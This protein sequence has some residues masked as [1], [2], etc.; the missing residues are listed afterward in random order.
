M[1]VLGTVAECTGIRM[2]QEGL[3]RRGQLVKCI[4]GLNVATCND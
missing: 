4:F 3:L 1:E 2:G